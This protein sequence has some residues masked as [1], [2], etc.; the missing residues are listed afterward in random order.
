MCVVVC[1]DV[2]VDVDVNV[3]VDRVIVSCTSSERLEPVKAVD[4]ARFLFTPIKISTRGDDFTSRLLIR[5]F[6]PNTTFCPTSGC[7]PAFFFFL[8]L[9]TGHQ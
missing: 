3:D 7:T 1:V 2:D 4:F 8:L 6:S 5:S 9:L